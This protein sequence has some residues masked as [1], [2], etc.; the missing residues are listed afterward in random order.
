MV[1]LFGIVKKNIKEILGCF[2]YHYEPLSMLQKFK[3]NSNCALFDIFS[4]VSK[5][6]HSIFPYRIIIIICN[7]YC[8][9]LCHFTHTFKSKSAWSF[10]ISRRCLNWRRVAKTN[11]LLFIVHV[12]SSKSI[13]H[14][15]YISF[16][17]KKGNRVKNVWNI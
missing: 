17:V 1:I 2:F 14:V 9:I 3:F 11:R 4:I 5:P 6:S 13:M 10:F 16:L 7:S 8:L 15:S 12:S